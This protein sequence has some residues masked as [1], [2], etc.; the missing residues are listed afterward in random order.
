LALN[1][2][3]LAGGRRDAVC[4]GGS[5]INKA[6]IPVANVPMVARVLQ[7]LRAVPAIERITVVAP[8]GALDDP[9]LALADV[10]R[11]AGER[12]V[13]SVQRG[14]EHSDPDAMN[15]LATSDA[16]LLSAASLQRFVEAL[17]A[18]DA[19]LVYGIAERK[20]H[21]RRFP[22]VPHTWARMRDG[23]FCGSAVFGVR[24]RVLPALVR[25]LDDLAAA[26]K[27]PLRLARFFGWDVVLRFALGA[28]S[29]GAAEA[30]ASAILG[31][32]V[33]A[34]VVEPDLAFNVDR[35][36]DLALAEKFAASS[37]EGTKSG[38]RS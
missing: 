3:V 9:A 11:A 38:P 29:I 2:L 15:L 35:K 22:G 26:R 36:T 4:E 12:I 14:F 27:R 5:A 37:P 24:P 33:R 21:E 34:V 16:P 1:A 8:F 7:T 25:F 28:L 31:H 20:A 23:V 19:D 10:R 32:R 30:R 13:E 18:T 17:A 6:F